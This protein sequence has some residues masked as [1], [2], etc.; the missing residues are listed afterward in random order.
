MKKTVSALLAVIV[1]L[2]AVSL[3]EKITAADLSEGS[4]LVGLLITTE[5][6]SAYADEAGVIF[7]FPT[8]KEPDAETEYS[9]EEIGGLRLICFIATDENGEGS[10]ISIAD[11]GISAV[12][13]EMSE[14]GGSV[15]MAAEI[16]Y[17]PGRDDALFFF[18]PVLLSLSGQVFAMPGD[19]MA[20]SAAMNPPG[21]C[22]GQTVRDQRTHTENGRQIT[23]AVSVD[24]RI[25]AVRK[26]LTI[27]LLQFGRTHELLR[28]EEFS[29]GA[30][31]ERIIPLAEAD[32]LL[33]ET[34][35]ADPDGESFIRRQ[36]FGRDADCMETLS[37]RDDGICLTH[38]HEILWDTE[39]SFHGTLSVDE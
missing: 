3:A 13:F 2:S 21:S 1:L 8:Q 7:A 36:V 22:I 16:R 27:R 18:N 19:F 30:V 11:D 15:N 5:D 10:V 34:E 31:P 32:Y 35:E 12:D 38:Y 26:P 28:S 25:L 4:R 14:D 24:V 29:P 17:V 33:L 39:G 20:V 37:C 6:P 23:D 9:F